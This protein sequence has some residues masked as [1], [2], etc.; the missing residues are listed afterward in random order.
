MSQHRY[1]IPRRSNELRSTS[2]QGD[3]KEYTMSP[4]ELLRFNSQLPPLDPI[5]VKSFSRPIK[6]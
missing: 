5:D 6:F 4:E 3:V 1:P 2:S